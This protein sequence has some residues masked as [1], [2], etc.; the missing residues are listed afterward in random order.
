[1]VS[2][3][4]Y[5][6][7]DRHARTLAPLSAIW[8]FTPLSLRQH[9]YPVDVEQEV[10]ILRL[11]DGEHPVVYG[12]FGVTRYTPKELTLIGRVREAVASLSQRMR[13]RACRPYFIFGGTIP[14]Y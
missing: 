7:N 12:R 11:A 8:G 14:C 10:E 5:Y 3:D 13:G 9:G 2:I 4:L 1:M 6:D